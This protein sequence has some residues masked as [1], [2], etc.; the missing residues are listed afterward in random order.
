MA[1]LSATCLDA[2]RLLDDS[3]GASHAALHS[4]H[5]AAGSGP[6]L[7]PANPC[8]G[9]A[10]GRVTADA[11]CSSSFP[12]NESSCI[13]KMGAGL[14]RQAAT[15]SAL[16]HGDLFPS[17]SDDSPVGSEDS[18]AGGGLFHPSY[19]MPPL[20]S[21]EQCLSTLLVYCSSLLAFSQ[22]ATHRSITAVQA[23][24]AAAACCRRVQQECHQPAL[25]KP[26]PVH[27]GTEAGL[28]AVPSAASL[29]FPL[30]NGVSVYLQSSNQ[31]PSRYPRQSFDR[32]SFRTKQ[33]LWQILAMAAEVAA[34]TQHALSILPVPDSLS[35]SAPSPLSDSSRGG[36]GS[37]MGSCFCCC[38]RDGRGGPSVFPVPRP[39][40]PRSREGVDFTD[41]EQFL[42]FLTANID[43]I[44]K[45]PEI[46]NL[47][48]DP[49][50]LC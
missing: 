11:P 40:P 44:S 8:C 46:T 41:D 27:F 18:P 24:D 3:C 33:T 37:G 45:L 10:V 39:E 25:E 47:Q 43:V 13:G 16:Q 28:H 2:S 50:S 36:S 17:H 29:S 26:S 22:A 12:G 48:L 21:W 35:D 49:R 32:S 31:S 14:P 23:A 7:Q 6:A 30:K 1:A 34:A 38:G 19:T 15:T 9:A 4:E 42:R 20:I 5:L